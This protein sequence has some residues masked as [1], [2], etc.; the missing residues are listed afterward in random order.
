MT[1]SV[2]SMSLN[3]GSVAPL[4]KD[5]QHEPP[6]DYVCDWFTIL[7]DLERSGFPNADVARLIG[8]PRTTL[9]GWKSGAQPRWSEGQKLL[10]LHHIKIKCRET[11]KG[12]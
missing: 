5:A 6:F 12:L 2:V 9:L 1:T 7:A 8:V 10:A 4:P 11:D 3:L